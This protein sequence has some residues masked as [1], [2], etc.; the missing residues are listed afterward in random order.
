MGAK[1]AIWKKKSEGRIGNTVE[2]FDAP[3][4]HFRPAPK[5][6]GGFC[7]PGRR[8][9]GQIRQRHGHAMNVNRP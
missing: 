3:G 9:A 4:G 2:L 8:R 1:M 6:R 7:H 5:G